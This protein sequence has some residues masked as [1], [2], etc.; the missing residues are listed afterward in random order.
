MRKVAA[1]DGATSSSGTVGG[2][3]SVFFAVRGDLSNCGGGDAVQT[4]ATAAALEKIGVRVTISS[5]H[6]ADLSAFDCV[7]LWHLERV[8]ET[9]A[10]LV[11]ARR[12]SKPTVLSTIYYPPKGKPF[13]A[14]RMFSFRSL[15]E[16]MKNRVRLRRAR[17]ESERDAIRSALL[18][19]W[20][21]C[22][23]ELLESAGVLL[24][25][26]RA[27][28]EILSREA[29]TGIRCIPVPNAID[30]DACRSVLGEQTPSRREGIVCVGHF[31][32]RKNQLALIRALKGAAISVTFIGAARRM[33]RRY[34]GR[35]RKLAGDDF[36]F[37]GRIDGVEVLRRLRSARLHVCPSRLETPGLANLEAAAMGCAL[38]LPD[39]PPVRE[40]FGTDAT[41]FTPADAASLKSAVIAAMDKPA[42]GAL[43]ERILT[44]YTWSAAATTTL[45]AYREA[46]SNL[47]SQISLRRP[48]GY[49]GQ[50]DLRL[51]RRREAR[52]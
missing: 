49:G 3:L 52:G 28:A 11:N 8:H 33:H 20:L 17:C 51:P 2:D 40:Y 38:V 42:P 22:R 10:H 32:P 5:D 9:Y 39:C 34:Y 18:K 14:G 50:A 37:A 13:V 15:K 47:K 26:S 35:C 27:E 44:E 19:G 6:T 16:D 41:Y 45:E 29:S 31:D 30:T 7:H 43:A 23:R 46:I 21:A 48:M 1:M 4:L 36:H 24:P 12:F 25:N